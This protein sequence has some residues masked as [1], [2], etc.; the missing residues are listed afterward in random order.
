MLTGQKPFDADSLTSLMYKIAR[1]Q[2]PAP[3]S[4][5]PRIPQIVEKII[6]KALEKDPGKRYQ[7]AGMMAEHLRKVV[8]KID[9]AKAK[10]DSPAKA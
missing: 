5:N 1:E 2:H 3:R 9:E 7:K 4:I 10:K 8:A 6:D